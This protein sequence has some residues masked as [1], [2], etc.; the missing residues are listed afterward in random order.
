[1]SLRPVAGL[2]LLLLPLAVRAQGADTRMPS[3][4][5][6]F[7]FHS[8]MWMNLHHFLHALSTVRTGGPNQRAAIAR[9]SSDTAG[10]GAL[11]AEL[12][13]GWEG[14][15]AYY[16][17]AM[18]PHDLLFDG[19]MYRIKRELARVGNAPTVRGSTLDSAHGAA[20]EAAAPAYRALWWPRH[21][22]ANRDWLRDMA[23]VLERY[24]DTVATQVLRAYRTTWVP[25][26]VDVSA[27]ANWAGAY[28]TEDPTHVVFASLIEASRGS[29]GLESL[30][31]E[32]MHGLEDSIVTSLER[33][34]RARRQEV[35][36]RLSHA[37][38]F[39]TAGE[40]VR[41]TVPDHTPYAERYGLWERGG[42]AAY[43]AA[44]VEGWKP[45]LDG[46]S[47]LDAA[48]DRVLGALVARRTGS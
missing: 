32:A 26:R 13:A 4:S 9:A 21:D 16:D 3:P 38:L 30:F 41:R 40:I 7:E 47:E 1:M 31:H 23:P 24:E 18:A 36:S 46:Q 14:A 8:A 27:Y 22:R 44:L 5:T 37:V 43:R 6:R 10:F 29:Q 48:M 35:P 34:A 19:R 42:W 28:A 39:F 20:L 17:T 15:L 11:P 45:Y 12:R 2:L 33:A 25:V